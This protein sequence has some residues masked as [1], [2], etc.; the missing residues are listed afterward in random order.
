MFAEDGFMRTLPLAEEKETSKSSS[1]RD[2]LL[3]PPSDSFAL[4][5]DQ[6]IDTDLDGK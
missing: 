5:P 4:T 1:L 6:K 2:K 3:K